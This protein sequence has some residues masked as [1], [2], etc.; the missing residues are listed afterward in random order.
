MIPI[1]SSAYN[2]ISVGLIICLALISSGMA[3]S[4]EAAK[5]VASAGKL[6]DPFDA[7]VPWVVSEGETSLKGIW[8]YVN[9]NKW[10]VA[11]TYDDFEKSVKTLNTG[12]DPSALQKDQVVILRGTLD[13]TTEKK[14]QDCLRQVLLDQTGIKCDANPTF[15]VKADRLQIV[16]AA[17]P[18]GNGIAVSTLLALW[19]KEGSLQKVPTFN[20][21]KTIADEA[22]TQARERIFYGKLGV[23]HFCLVEYN[24]AAK[25][26]LLVD[27]MVAASNHFI[28][29]A[30][31][32]GGAAVPV[33]IMA[34]LTTTPIVGSTTGETF[35]V[36]ASD[37]FFT[38]SLG[39]GARFFQSLLV[40]EGPDITYIHWNM[41][42]NT[43]TL[44]VNS[45]A[46]NPKRAA[47]G[48][49]NW[50]IHS[51]VLEGEFYDPRRNAVRFYFYRKSF[52]QYD[53]P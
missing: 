48:F 52:L 16:R 25:D 46:T 4:V 47:L 12:I 49:V 13:L 50:A 39:L 21:S 19:Q 22:K 30:T 34:E 32:Y 10:A 8:E 7:N 51:P 41:R 43:W 27:D 36:E 44:M 29:E 26:N 45:I 28:T 11:G 53:G 42:S 37:Q 40:P 9:H 33:D 14:K 17:A 35:K 15:S 18:N 31:K 24:A 20:S 38:L 23:D 6:L 3:F 5:P 2:L 1:M